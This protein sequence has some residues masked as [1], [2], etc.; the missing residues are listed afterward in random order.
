MIRAFCASKIDPDHGGFRLGSLPLVLFAAIAVMP[1]PVPNAHA[2]PSAPVGAITAEQRARIEQHV[3][4]EHRPSI[5]APENF[6]PTVGAALPTG[7]ELY[8]M[9]PAVEL[10]RF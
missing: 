3:R 4:A 9:S 7:I 8:W 2:Q 10:N 6:I 1:G 5:M